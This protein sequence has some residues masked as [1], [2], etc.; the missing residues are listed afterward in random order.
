MFFLSL[1]A[2]FLPVNVDSFLG[3]TAPA[4][5]GISVPALLCTVDG[6]VAR[7]PLGK[8]TVPALA[9]GAI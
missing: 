8:K 9:S 4:C 1:M 7:I 2:R 6:F 3:G 5:M